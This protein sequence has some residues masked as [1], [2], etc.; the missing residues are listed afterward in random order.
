MAEIV[1]LIEVAGVIPCQV[2]DA[3]AEASE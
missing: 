3:T 1:A 2:D